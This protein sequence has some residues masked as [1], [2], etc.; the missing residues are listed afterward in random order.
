VVLYINKF[1]GIFR[2][3]IGLPLGDRPIVVQMSCTLVS[4]SPRPWHIRIKIEAQTAHANGRDTA[5]SVK[6]LAF[7]PK[8][9]GK[10]TMV[11]KRKHVDWDI[12][13]RKT[14]LVHDFYIEKWPKLFVSVNIL[15]QTRF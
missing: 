9:K 6:V 15:R 3:E 5:I 11:K 1:S 7:S 14:L 10:P 2:G 12:F 8:S 4:T 13:D